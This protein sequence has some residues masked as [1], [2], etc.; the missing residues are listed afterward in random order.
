MVAKIPTPP[1]RRSGRS[2]GHVRIPARARR[3]TRGVRPGLADR[4]RALTPEGITAATDLC[5]REAAETALTLGAAAEWISNLV[6]I[7]L[8]RPAYVSSTWNIDQG[9]PS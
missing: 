9:K 4:V 2:G 6:K 7:L 3:R 1:P 8:G 5:G